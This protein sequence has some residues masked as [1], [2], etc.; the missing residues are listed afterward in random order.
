MAIHYVFLPGEFLGQR[1]PVDYS[2]WDHKELDTIER[3]TLSLYF[4]QSLLL[5]QILTRN[6]YPL[7]LSYIRIKP[8]VNYLSQKEILNVGKQKR[9]FVKFE[10]YLTSN[11]SLKLFLIVAF[12]I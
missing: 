8:K 10:N 11:K 12:N 5:F 3:I 4:T 6:R 7:V 9:Q 2:S 1:S